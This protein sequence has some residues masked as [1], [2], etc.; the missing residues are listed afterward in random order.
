V[1]AAVLLVVLAAAERIPKPETEGPSRAASPPDRRRQAALVGAL[2]ALGFAALLFDASWTRIASLV[3]GGTAYGLAVETLTFLLGIAAGC[4][5]VSAYFLKRPPEG[6]RALAWCL[7][8]AGFLAMVSALT[9]K[10]LPAV[11]LDWHRSLPA[12]EASLFGAPFV[13]SALLLFPTTLALGAAL[14]LGRS[15]RLSRGSRAGAVLCGAATGVVISRV[16]LIGSVGIETTLR[17]GTLAS[18]AAALVL[19][20]VERRFIG[21]GVV[22][23]AALVVLGLE[24]SWEHVAKNFGLYADPGRYVRYDAATLRE[25]MRSYAPLFYE[26]GATSTVAV[27]EVGR[28]RLLKTD[29]RTEASTSREDMEGEILLA[30]LPLMA[31]PS[32]RVAVLGWVSGMTVGSLLTHDVSSVDVFE[33]EPAVVEASAFFETYNRAPFRD[34]R[35]RLV[36]R[37]PRVALQRETEPYDLIVSAP[38]SPWRGDASSLESLE[39]FRLAAARLSPSGIFC[40]RFPLTGV[41]LDLLQ[42]FVAT[43]RR[44]FPH[45]VLFSRDSAVLLGSR[46]PIRF[47]LE[48]MKALFAREAVS[49]NL[50]HVFVRY[51]GDLLVDFRLD[52]RGAEAFAGARVVNTD[53]NLLLELAAPRT[54]YRNDRDALVASMGP[55]PASLFGHL[56]GYTSR[57]DVEIEL[58]ASFFTQGRKRE[59]LA[60]CERALLEKNTF[61]GRKLQ[62]QVLSSLGRT[63]DARAALQAALRLGGDPEGRRFVEALLRS[64]AIRTAAS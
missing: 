39:F 41:S 21:A 50:S 1:I 55:V 35:V 14:A 9:A 63:D 43:F 19:L 29:G 3:Y 17:L 25:Q 40:Q 28:Y 36:F 2:F 34:P 38:G 24:P 27:Q 15:E 18:F 10:R 44:E 32:G 52:A 53:D 16:F 58:G 46:E 8:G 30:H 60:A 47:D 6:A 33:L 11:L 51:P 48:R 64:L 57:A 5:L 20:G 49:Q 42:S 62:G 23:A 37:D 56:L 31:A 61:E 13:V 7:A 59:A 45:V 12:G 26:D 4:A 22:A 54:A